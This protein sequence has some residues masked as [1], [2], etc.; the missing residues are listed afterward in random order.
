MNNTREIE[1]RFTTHDLHW[2]VCDG[3]L[4]E[5]LVLSFAGHK[6]PKIS[7]NPATFLI[8]KAVLSSWST[9]KP[10]QKS[11]TQF[12]MSHW[13]DL[14]FIL[15]IMTVRWNSVYVL[16]AIIWSHNSPMIF[17]F[18]FFF[19]FCMFAQYDTMQYNLFH[20]SELWLNMYW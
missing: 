16:E 12:F 7:R 19:L 1:F 8:S 2:T 10:S 3:H 15:E 11:G 5:V 20:V 6:K 14:L 17:V 4:K 13:K 18:D 9:D